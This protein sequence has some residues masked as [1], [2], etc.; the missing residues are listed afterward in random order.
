MLQ[1]ALLVE[2]CQFAQALLHSLPGRDSFSRGLLGRLG[3]IVARGL[4]LLPAVTHIQMRTMLG[5]IAL[6]MA[7]RSCAGAVGF[8]QRSKDSDLG[9]TCDLAQQLASLGC[10]LN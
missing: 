3:N 10:A 4:P 2:F 7:A 6:T 5:S 1:I 9:Q 8:R